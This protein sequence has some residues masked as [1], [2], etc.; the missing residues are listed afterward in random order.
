MA[1]SQL[2]R[3]PHPFNFQVWDHGL[4]AQELIRRN[5]GPRAL[6]AQ[7]TRDAQG[8]IV[9]ATAPR[10]RI[11][12]GTFSGTAKAMTEV[13]HRIETRFNSFFDVLGITPSIPIERSMQEVRGL[14][15]W[16]PSQGPNADKYPPHLSLI[17]D[18]PSK[19]N[20][21]QI[22]DTMRLLDTGFVLA[23]I[24]PEDIRDFI[25]SSP[26]QG[27]T[28][29]AL[30]E[31]NRQL[32]REKK[33]ILEEPNVGDCVETPWYTDESFGQ[34]QFTGTNPATIEIASLKWITEFR[35]EAVKQTR[36]DVDRLL[37]G[38][39]SA[40]S[41]YVQD[42]SYFRDAVGAPATS[43]L[44][45]GITDKAKVRYACATVSLFVLTGEGKLHPCAIVIDY[46]QDMAHSVV[47]F[48]ERL[49]PS[50]GKIN[51]ATDWPWRYAKTCASSADWIR[52]EVKVH[53]TDCHFVE[54][55]TIVAAYRAFPPEHLV[56]RCLQPHW[57]KT[58]PLNAAA[59]TTLVP[60]VVI[61]L[62]GLDPNSTY[63]F[64]RDAYKRFDWVGH[65]VPNHLN[66]RGFPIEELSRPDSV[67]F[68]NYAYGKEILLMWQIIRKFVKAFLENGGKGFTDVS[69]AADNAIKRWCQEMQSETGGQMGD[70]WPNIETLDDLVDCV[71][72][73]IHIASPQHT[74]V[75]Y[76]QEYYNSYVVNKPPAICSSLPQTLQ[77]L[78]GYRERELM[79]ALPVGRSNEWLL[80]SHLVHLLSY[81]VAED[82]NLYNY[83][84]SL[85]RLT[86]SEEESGL[87]EA[88]RSFVND[89]L[90]FVDV[91]Q[92]ISDRLDN[93][94]IP[95]R[96]L[97]PK[98][99][100]VSILI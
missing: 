33:N 69:V 59:R 84:V 2:N 44:S 90:D 17:P 16:S 98:A 43:T 71:T 60:H 29:A 82:Q 6:T 21:F 79:L 32:R 47:I 25:Y 78:S 86:D 46:K 91:V 99:N 96:V 3:L 8:L 4:V 37:E 56:Y 58:L 88:A 39:A 36:T 61:P 92:N 20:P 23:S 14:Y 94:E 52:H 77:E 63:N 42:C 70:K 97:E 51:Q 73:C 62:I 72:M 93:Q 54:E 49:D 22:F 55:A 76:L 87:H 67:K 35:A 1:S 89:L 13:Y 100:A 27:D 12:R 41:L 81:R 40:K 74:A 75:N 66:K 11:S 38:A 26:Y 10:T 30:D 95:Y 64:I 19:L 34:Q 57:L 5:V 9:P 65:Y 83:G 80:A 24:I 85:F 68:H 50:N 28:M 48:N 45:A 18:G 7:E 53:L 31:R 15:E